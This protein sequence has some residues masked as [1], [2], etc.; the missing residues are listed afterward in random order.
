[1]RPIAALNAG[2]KACPSSYQCSWAS[3]PALLSA[4]I[5]GGGPARRTGVVDAP[6]HHQHGLGDPVEVRAGRVLAPEARILL[7]CAPPTGQPVPKA[8]V[9]R[10][11]ADEPAVVLR[12]QGRDRGPRGGRLH[13][14]RLG[15]E[16]LHDHAP[17]HRAAEEG[18][19]I[20]VDGNVRRAAQG[21]D[22]VDHVGAVAQP[23][24][25][26]RQGV[27]VRLGVVAVVHMQGDVAVGGQVAALAGHPLAPHV[28][29]RVDE[30]VRQHHGREGATPA[31]H[32]EDPRDRVGLLA[33]RQGAAAP[34]RHVVRRVG[35]RPL[36]DPTQPQSITPVT[37]L[38]Q[39]EHRD[40]PSRRGARR[41]RWPGVVDR[42]T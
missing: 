11:G 5:G 40:R 23:H 24:P 4:R 36:P 15:D 22:R 18:D 27:V 26:L 20:V 14:T 19:P 35:R 32:V 8:G 29:G 21:L 30:A 16:G 9:L 38:G 6:V 39:A 7:G 17:A 3:T 13:Q 37:L 42:I 34:V 41:C 10:I 12:L 33:S 31:R 1:M 25:D 28:D 2:P